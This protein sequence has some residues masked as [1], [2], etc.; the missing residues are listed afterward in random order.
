MSGSEQAIM[1]EAMVSVPKVIFPSD[2]LASLNMLLHPALTEIPSSVNVTDTVLPSA[3][4]IGSPSNVY[5]VVVNVRSVRS[6]PAVESLLQ[7]VA[8]I[9]TS[10]NESTLIKIL[11]MPTQYVKYPVIQESDWKNPLN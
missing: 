4:V 10:T 3:A 5:S 1:V 2:K 8:N 9:P 11:F 6:V 7:P